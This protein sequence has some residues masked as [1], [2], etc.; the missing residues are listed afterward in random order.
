MSY[1][2]SGVGAIETEDGNGSLG[3]AGSGSKGPD[4]SNAESGGTLGGSGPEGAEDLSRQH[5]GRGGLDGVEGGER[6]AFVEI[7]FRG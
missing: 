3:L 1:Q 2:S 7:A 4:R 6:P 5:G